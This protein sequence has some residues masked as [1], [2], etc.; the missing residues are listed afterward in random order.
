MDRKEFKRCLSSAELGLGKK[1]I[2]K[3][4]AEADENEDGVLE[5]REF[6]PVM[7]E[8]I[9]TLKAKEEAA[10][11]KEAA[12]EMAREEVEYQLLHNM[13]REELEQLM[14]SIFM[15]ADTDG[16]GSLEYKEFKSCL[17]SA[18]LGLNRR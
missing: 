2:K 15:A 1:D 13:P 6:M 9:H 11:A 12:E 7:V 14:A 8:V 18:D 4:M 5:Y 16:S 3:L 17:T 10:M